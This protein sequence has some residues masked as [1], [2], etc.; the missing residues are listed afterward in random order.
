M[1]GSVFARNVLNGNF[2][3]KHY[4]NETTCSFLNQDEIGENDKIP[5]EMKYNLR[6]PPFQVKTADRE[7]TSE[8]GWFASGRLKF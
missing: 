5:Q 1:R 3:N 6:I 4:R 2:K 7:R 8:I